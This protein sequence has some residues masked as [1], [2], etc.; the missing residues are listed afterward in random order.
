MFEPIAKLDG[1]V[2]AVINGFGNKYHLRSKAKIVSASGDGPVYLYLCVG[3]LLVNQ[4]GEQVFNSAL[5]AF[6]IELPLYLVLKNSIRRTRPCYQHWAA[7]GPTPQLDFQPSDKFSLPSG[8]TAAAFVMATT[9]A[10]VFPSLAWLGFGWAMLIGLS[11]IL[12]GVHYPL[13]IVAGALLG[14]SSCYLTQPMF[15]Q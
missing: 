6:I 15:G 2:F 8:H 5:A 7:E 3:L 1:Q 10:W 9:L 12:L 14:V 11:R 4:Q 13:D